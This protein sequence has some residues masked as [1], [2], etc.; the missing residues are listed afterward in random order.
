MRTPHT[1]KRKLSPHLL[2]MGLLSVVGSFALGISTSGDIQTVQHSSATETILAG[3]LTAD[4]EINNK[5]VI[6]ILEI[7]EG[8]RPATPRELQADPNGN[9]R[10]T[11]DDALRLLS[12]LSER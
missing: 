7:A 3:D 4:G 11:V 2:A 6:V 10:I 1:R 8:Y 12:T 5:D 9:G